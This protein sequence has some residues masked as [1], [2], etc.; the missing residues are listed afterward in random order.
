M[1]SAAA[2]K[3]RNQLGRT[4]TAV[5][6]KRP[7]EAAVAVVVP[8]QLSATVRDV[9]PAGDAFVARKRGAEVSTVWVRVQVLRV[10]GARLLA[11][12][13]AEFC[14]TEFKE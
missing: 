2:G 3:R 13:R 11:Q 1:E 9:L 7:G 5:P 10:Q 4:V 12:T 14:H 6:A 8:L